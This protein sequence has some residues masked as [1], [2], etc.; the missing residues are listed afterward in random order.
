MKTQHGCTQWRGI[1]SLC[2]HKELLLSEQT[3]HTILIFTGLYTNYKFLPSLLRGK[4]LNSTHST[5]IKLALVTSSTIHSGTQIEN[6]VFVYEG[7]RDHSKGPTSTPVTR[8]SYPR[9][10]PSRGCVTSP[11]IN[12][13]PPLKSTQFVKSSLT[14]NP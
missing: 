1:R 10:L 8:H 11:N 14:D 2:R 7:P 6:G 3:R 12:T 13:A 9:L 4:P 5:F